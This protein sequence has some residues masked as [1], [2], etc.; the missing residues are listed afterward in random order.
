[1][2]YSSNILTCFACLICIVQ[3]SA[4]ADNGTF[5][6]VAPFAVYVSVNGSKMDKELEERFVKSCLKMLQ[7]ANVPTVKGEHLT[8]ETNPFFHWEFW[9][10]RTQDGQLSC[11]A[12]VS[13][14]LRTKNPINKTVI[15]GLLASGFKVHFLTAAENPEHVFTYFMRENTEGIVRLWR[16]DNPH[17][18]FAASDSRD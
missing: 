8:K 14:K 7:E 3:S 12:R 11:L 13:V 17:T 15:D 10:R 18:E 1:M 9:V 4:N 2:F 16:R 6:D 5:R